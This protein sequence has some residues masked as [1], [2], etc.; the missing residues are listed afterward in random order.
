MQAILRIL[1]WAIAIGGISFA[2]GFIGPMIV[3][4]DANQ[5]PMLGIFITGPLGFAA[6]LLIGVVR[7]LLGRTKTPSDLLHDVDWT[8]ARRGTAAI[9]AIILA[10]SAV[11]NAPHG[12]D[13]GVAASFILSV[14][15]FWYSISGRLPAWFRR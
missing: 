8:I 6:G 12:V 10:V 3:V 13:R 11:R 7:E 5:G 14:A 4:P 2:V 15:L 9:V 1:A